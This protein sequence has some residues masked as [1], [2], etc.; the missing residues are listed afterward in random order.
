MK[1]PYAATHQRAPGLKVR[2]LVF[3]AALA[4]GASAFAKNSH[5]TKT[6]V[7]NITKKAVNNVKRKQPQTTKT[8]TPA[9]PVALPYPN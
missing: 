5:D 7:N 1:P 3:S 9:G 2:A 8:P 4:L 6:G